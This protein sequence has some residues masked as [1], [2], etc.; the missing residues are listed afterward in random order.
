MPP[1]LNSTLKTFLEFAEP[2]QNLENF[3]K[4]QQVNQIKMEETMQQW[5]WV[6][7]HKGIRRKWRSSKV[8]RTPPSEG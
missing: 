8:A 1:D 3:R 7:A 6:S 2:L 4:T 5:F